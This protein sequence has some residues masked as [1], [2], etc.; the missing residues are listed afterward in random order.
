VSGRQFVDAIGITFPLRIENSTK[1]LSMDLILTNIG[2]E[3]SV[4]LQW[5]LGSGF[6]DGIMPCAFYVVLKLINMKVHLLS[7]VY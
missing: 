1:N 7:L 2:L 3:N 4:V 6:P 5:V